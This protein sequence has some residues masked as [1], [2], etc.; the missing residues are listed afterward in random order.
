MN[1]PFFVARRYLFSKKSTNIINIL[2][3][4]SLLGVLLS[5]A[6]LVIVVSVFNGFEKQIVDSYNP[7]S[8]DIRIEPRKGKTFRND[9]LLAEKIERLEQVA[10]VLPVVSER[11]ILEFE[12]RILIANA[13]GVSKA[14]ENV[15]AIDSLMREGAFYTTYEEKEY[16]VMGYPLAARLQMNLFSVEPLA[17]YAL[18]SGRI[19]STNLSQAFRKRYIRPAGYFDGYPEFS[20]ENIFISFSFAQELF[21]LQNRISYWDLKLEIEANQGEVVKE[22]AKLVGD[23]FVVKTRFQLNETLFRMLKIEKF[24][25]FVTLAIIF[26]IAAFNIVGALSMIISDKREDAMLLER[27][28]ATT[29]L[30]T[31]IFM[32]ESLLIATLGTFF[33]LLLGLFFCMLQSR[34]GIVVMHMSSTSLPFPVVVRFA[35]ILLVLVVSLSIGFFIAI[36]T[37]KQIVKSK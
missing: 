16:V 8:P 11:V 7:I 12:G 26:L 4:L 31:R 5:T 22:I 2:S 13:L 15:Y 9:T 14:V 25:V 19:K 1:F 18:K 27:L 17:I 21:Q 37:V 33:G 35:D 3:I 29:Q 30:T 34:Y 24:F 10:Q 6:A 20:A 23:E 36:V 28:G 32:M